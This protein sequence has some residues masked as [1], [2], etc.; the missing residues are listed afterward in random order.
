MDLGT[1]KGRR[2]FIWV[3]VDLSYCDEQRLGYNKTVVWLAGTGPQNRGYWTIECVEQRDAADGEAQ[4]TVT[5]YARDPDIVAV[6]LFGRHMRGFLASRDLDK[7]DEPDTFIK[8]AWSD[9]SESA[10]DDPDSDPRDKVAMVREVSRMLAEDPRDNDPPF[11]VFKHGGPVRH[12]SGTGS[13]VV[14]STAAVLGPILEHIEEQ[15]RRVIQPRCPRR[16]RHRAKTEDTVLEPFPF[17]IHKRIAMSPIGQPLATLESPYELIIVLT[18]AMRAHARLLECGI[19]HRDISANNILV[20][21]GPDNNVRGVLTDLDCAIRVGVER[22]QRPE[23]TGTPPFMSIS[24]LENSSVP[25]SEL[26]DWESALYIACWL[27]V[28][29]V[30]EVDRINCQEE[31]EEDDNWVYCALDR[32][33]AGSFEDIAEAKRIHVGLR[34]EFHKNILMWFMVGDGYKALERL[35]IEM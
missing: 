12:T 13:H 35:V 31:I 20:V 3:L 15:G 7:V 29:G 34:S 19:L 4:L 6:R 14:E 17:R 24:N 23:R 11:I 16:G 25:R 9:T 26:D 33:D 5:Y 32:W 22:D 1:S 28:Y 30:S 2:A 21:R 18:D 8:Y 10:R 27:G